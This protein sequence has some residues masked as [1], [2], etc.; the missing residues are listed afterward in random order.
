MRRHSFVLLLA[1]IC[2]SFLLTHSKP[3]N[4]IKIETE[5]TTESDA[6]DD[7]SAKEDTAETGID[8]LPL[9]CCFKTIQQSNNF[10]FCGY[11]IISTDLIPTKQ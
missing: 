11:C 4:E 2:C 3:V 6:D 8:F 5:S 1:L 7:V 9:F 10:L